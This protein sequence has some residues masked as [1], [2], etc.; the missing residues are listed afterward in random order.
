MPENDWIGWVPF[1][2]WPKLKNPER[3][4]IATTN[5]RIMDDHAVYNFG[6]QMTG[7]SRSDRLN[8]ILPKMIASGQKITV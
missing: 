8:D 6:L 2:H 3:G 4:F 1:D 7:N 5:Q